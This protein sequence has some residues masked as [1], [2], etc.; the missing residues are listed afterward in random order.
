MKGVEEVI[1]SKKEGGQ[2][3]RG[4]ELR[5]RIVCFSEE[6]VVGGWGCYVYVWVRMGGCAT[7]LAFLS[8]S[9]GFHECRSWT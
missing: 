9:Y 7:N 2:K 8:L 1:H 6:V 5:K 3:E 4:R